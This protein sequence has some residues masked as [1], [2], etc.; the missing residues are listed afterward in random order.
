MPSD[1]RVAAALE[2]LA[3]RREAFRGAI[4]VAAEQLRSLIRDA[5]R[6]GGD[7]E[8]RTQLELG[9]FARGRLRPDAFARLFAGASAPD[10]EVLRTL[11]DAHAV[12]LEVAEKGEL[13]LHRDVPS[14]ESLLYHAD[15]ALASPARAFGA[16]HAAE[17]AR[18]GRPP[19]SETVGAPYAPHRWS[20]AERE[21]APPVVLEV[22]GADAQA[23]GLARHLAGAQKVVLVIRPPMPPALLARLITPGVMVLQTDDPAELSLLGENPGP[24]IAALVDEGA[25][26]FL[27]LPGPGATW[28]RTTL[29]HTPRERPRGALGSFT[30]FQQE[31]ELLLLESLARAPEVVPAARETGAPEPEREVDPAERLAA[32]LLQ[33]AAPPAAG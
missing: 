33:E 21:L 8:E 24:G 16:I 3:P 4:L 28:E 7:A 14:G 5:E 32:W 11:Q 10:P 22:D 9:A 19:A 20:R 26:R 15:A 30:A 2:A 1:P 31:Q 27:H 17:L 29:R 6:S 18:Q 12:L 23:S 13:L 25:A